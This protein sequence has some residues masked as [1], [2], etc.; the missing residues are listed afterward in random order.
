MSERVET[1]MGLLPIEWKVQELG[2]MCDILDSQRVPLNKETRDKKRGDIPY[3]GANGV[4]DYIDN[5]IFDEE[6]IL[7]A[8]DG[9]YFNEYKNRPIAYKISGKSWVNN[10]AHIL[11]AK[12]QVYQDWLYYSLVHKNVLPFISGGTRAKLNQSA[13]KKIPIAE[14]PLK[15]QQK[16]VAILTSVDEAIDKTEA[17][18]KQTEKVKKG[19][20]QQL[21][22]KG[23]GHTEF[24]E[25]EIGKIPVKWNLSIIDNLAKV[26]RLAGYEYSEVWKTDTNGSIIALRGYNI[27]ENEIKLKDVERITEE[28][29]QRL[30]RSRLFKGDIVFPCVGTIGKAVL[31]EENDKYHINQNIAK[32]T[33]DRKIILPEFLVHV[34]MSDVTKKQIIKFNTSSSQPNV[35][36]GSLR[37]FLVP[38]PPVDEQRKISSI[39]NSL[40]TKIKIEKEQLEKLKILKQG[41]MRN[42]LTGKIRVKVDEPEVVS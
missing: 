4:L 42:L 10:H 9:G 8:E 22:T 7:M 17:I 18:V 15:E 27:G 41:L 38:I 32:I 31:I 16:I 40:A 2:K 33:A 36:V 5:Y 19:L 1:V 26:T 3:Y 30:V 24:K 25:T 6:L 23:I 14:P 20:M 29:S 34:L 37:Q 35:L 21:L 12:D 13:L 11:R 28:L 39:I